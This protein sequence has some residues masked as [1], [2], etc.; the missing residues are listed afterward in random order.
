MPQ[1][2]I[3]FTA[4]FK[5]ANQHLRANQYQKAIVFYQYA[6]QHTQDNSAL[7]ENLGDAL[8][9]SQQYK[10]AEAAYQ[11]ALSLSPK[12][13][14]ARAQLGCIYFQQQRYQDAI[15]AH[16]QA[17]AHQPTCIPFSYDLAQITPHHK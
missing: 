10:K 15:T 2:G 16:R 1:S 5:L 17:I 9:A 13:S 7:Y 6:L 8:Y 11:Q 4:D 3:D 14:Y 12:S